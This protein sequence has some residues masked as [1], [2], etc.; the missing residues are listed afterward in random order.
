M[1]EKPKQPEKTQKT[2]E[3][4]D[5]LLDDDFFG[6]GEEVLEAL[7]EAEEENG[8]T[9]PPPNPHERP[10]VSMDSKKTVRIRTRNADSLG[11]KREDTDEDDQDEFSKKSEGPTRVRK[12]D[13]TVPPPLPEK[14]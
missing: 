4:I 9:S 3:D 12:N 13:P 11:L 8:Q 5:K 14:D 7:V 6:V 1:S 2:P 10:T